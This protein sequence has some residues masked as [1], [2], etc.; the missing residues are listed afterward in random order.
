MPEPITQK[1]LAQRLGIT[2]N[3][4]KYYIKTGKIE[5]VEKYGRLLVFPT[6]A[7]NPRKNKSKALL[8]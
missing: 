6:D 5:T 3:H 8:K 7:I 1:E 4:I 2:L